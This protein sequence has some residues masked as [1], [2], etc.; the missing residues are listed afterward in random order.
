MQ[1][2]NEFAARHQKSLHAT[3]VLPTSLLPEKCV[4]VP[5]DELDGAICLCHAAKHQSALSNHL[6]R[7]EGQAEHQLPV[8]SAD[9]A[10]GLQAKNA[11]ADRAPHGG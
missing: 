3:V 2:Y 6:V 7:E 4:V 9:H 5:H 10:E 8:A 1:R 11:D